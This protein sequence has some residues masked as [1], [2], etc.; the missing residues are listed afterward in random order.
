MSEK[1]V[2]DDVHESLIGEGDVKT[3]VGHVAKFDRDDK[4]DLEEKIVV[5]NSID[6]KKGNEF[7]GLTKEVIL[8]I[9]LN[10]K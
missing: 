1:V 8:I 9:Y 10:N 2:V 3:K 4:N 5:E 6:K 7:V